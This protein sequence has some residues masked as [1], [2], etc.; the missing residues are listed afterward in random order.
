[1]TSCGG[2]SGIPTLPL[3]PKDEDGEEIDSSAWVADPSPFVPEIFEQKEFVQSIYQILDGLPE[4]Y[5]TVLTLVDLYGL[6]YEEAAA[7]LG[8]PIGTV[9]SRLARSR[10]RMK[11][12]LQSRLEYEAA[13]YHF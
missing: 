10:L 5:R 1:M 12:K 3:F 7:S 8:V 13:V 6:G 4:A 11:E 2:P 9:K